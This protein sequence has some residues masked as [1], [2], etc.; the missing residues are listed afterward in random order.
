MP[1]EDKKTPTEEELLN[2]ILLAFT[3]SYDHYSKPSDELIAFLADK[4]G[5]T[6]LIL[7]E[8]YDQLLKKYKDC[9]WNTIKYLVPHRNDKA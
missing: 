2:E 1:E 6:E 9:D 7:K 8:H 3:Y 4:F 5:K